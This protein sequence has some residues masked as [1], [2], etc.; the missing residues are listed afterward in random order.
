MFGD[1]LKLAR[2]K[3]GYSLRGLS[4][5]LDNHVTAQALG[6][7]ERDEM[8]PSSGVLIRLSKTLSVSLEYL[9]SEQ[10][11]ELEAVEFRKLSR[12][13]VGE[14]ARVS[15]EVI[16]CLQRYLTIEEILGLDSGVWHAPQSG[17][18]FLGQEDDGEIVAED[19]RREWQLGIDPIPNMTA[20]LED[21]GIK[22]LVLELPERVSGLT[23]L[24]RRHSKKKKVPVIVVNRKTTLERRR[25]TLAHELAH[26]LIDESSPVDHEKASNV[27]AGAFLVPRDHL[28]REIGEARK[29]IGYQELIQLKRM[30]RVSAATLL[31]R[32]KQ[33]GVISESTLAYAFQTFARGWR[34]SE[35]EPLEESSEEGQNEA[36]R[37][38][39]RLCYW[40]LAEGLISPVKA[41]ELLQQPRN[42]IEQGLRG[43]AEA[44][45]DYRQ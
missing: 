19:M 39:E 17:N 27:F 12:T 36:P 31:V 30:Y 35:P 38:F 42:K 16:D 24:V 4:D 29:A 18:R 20:L 14:R 40:A 28:V 25:F 13:S 37:R 33:V 6:K 1:R 23:C 34:S 7:Y 3:S 43:P 21:W 8:M 32:F 26:R 10:V 5:A 2:K 44:D 11:E 41:G 15:A 45:E 9:L 22:V